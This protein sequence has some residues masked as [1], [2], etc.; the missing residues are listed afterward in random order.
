VE[1][2]TSA[3]RGRLGPESIRALVATHGTSWR[4]VLARCDKDPALAARLSPEVVYPAAAVQHAVEDEMAMT[5]ADVV[6]R[7]LPIGAAGHPGDQAVAACGAIMAAAL[8]WDAER[9][10]AEIEAVRGFYRID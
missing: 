4:P 5:L 6:I 8:G 7:R 1:L 3:A 2:A 9:L 10:A